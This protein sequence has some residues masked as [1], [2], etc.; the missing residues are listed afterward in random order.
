[1]AEH[2]IR[3]MTD[4]ELSH[5][6]KNVWYKVVNKFLGVEYAPTAENYI[7]NL[8]SNRDELEGDDD[9]PYVYAVYLNEILPVSRAEMIVMAWDHIYPRDFQ[10]ESSAEYDPEGCED[11]EF[12]IDD[13]MYEEIQKRASKFLHNRWV[14]HQI[15]EGWRFGL[16]TNHK[17]K[18][19]PKLRD[20]DSLNEQ[21]RRELDMTREQAVQF[22]QTYP[23][24]FV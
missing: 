18:T 23:H 5:K 3:L 11:C 20:W 15:Q 21:Y 24:L 13:A 19:T 22:L 1:M 12:E 8:I 14:E 7:N 9:Y 17:E 6:Q 10:I 2:Y 4:V 16:K